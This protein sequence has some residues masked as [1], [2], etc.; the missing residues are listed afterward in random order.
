MQYNTHFNYTTGKMVIIEEF[1]FDINT[2]F[3]TGS[4]GGSGISIDDIADLFMAEFLADVT[5]EKM[6]AWQI[7]LMFQQKEDASSDGGDDLPLHSTS[8]FIYDGAWKSS[9]GIYMLEAGQHVKVELTNMNILGV[10]LDLQDITTYTYE[11]I[12]F[13]LINRKVYTG[14]SHSMVLLPG[15]TQSFDFFTDLIIHRK[16]GGFKLAHLLVT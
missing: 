10:Q 5:L 8:S 4:G 7:K 2:S 6:I 11:K 16:I 1:S 12:F 15:Q 14:D 3:D 9:D 13:G